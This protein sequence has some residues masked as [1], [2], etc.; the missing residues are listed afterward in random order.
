MTDAL[1]SSTSCRTSLHGEMSGATSARTQQIDTFMQGAGFDARL[2]STIAR[3]MWEKWVLLATLGGVTC[4]M[5][6][7]IGE[8]EA[9][10]GGAD[11]VLR[12]LDEVVSVVGAVGVAPSETFVASARALFTARAR[13]R[14]RRCTA[15]CRRAVRS[16]SSRLSATCW[17]GHAAPP[18]RRRCWL[19]LA[20]ISVYQNRVMAA[21]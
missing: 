1:S 6:G 2:S 15:T 20:H 5:R 16:R 7:A 19:W 17:P 14:L 10:P 21:G 9:A 4:L 12:F 13:R 3:E 18:L 8:I 11:F